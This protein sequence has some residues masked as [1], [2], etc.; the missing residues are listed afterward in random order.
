[1]NR[2]RSHNLLVKQQSLNHRVVKERAAARR[3]ATKMGLKS[4]EAEA[5]IANRIVDYE[6]SEIVRSAVK[7]VQKRGENLNQ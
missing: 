4:L 6:K 1:M 7:E 2:D 5:Y 3:E